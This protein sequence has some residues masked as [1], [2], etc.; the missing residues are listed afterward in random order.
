M[1]QGVYVC[2]NGPSFETPAEVRFLRLIGAD[3]VGMSTVSEAIVARHGG[4]RV[5]AISGISNVVKQEQAS[6]ETTHEEVL[7]AGKV[8]APRL[9]TVIH[10]V[11]GSLSVSGG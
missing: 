9:E 2:L 3:A 5:L 7:G 1:H 6:G 11:L 10:G 4:L 8:L